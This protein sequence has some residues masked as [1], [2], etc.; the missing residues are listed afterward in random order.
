MNCSLCIY[1]SVE[2]RRKREIYVRA[3]S[4]RLTSSGQAGHGVE[5]RDEAMGTGVRCVREWF[6]KIRPK[7]S[8]VHDFL[9]SFIFAISPCLIR[10]DRDRPN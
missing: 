1:K 3:H 9:L 6:A 8:Q 5:W 4:P 2:E 7:V 10:F